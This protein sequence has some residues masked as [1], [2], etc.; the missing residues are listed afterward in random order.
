MTFGNLQHIYL[1]IYA[2]VFGF[3][4]VLGVRAKLKLDINDGSAAVHLESNA[5]HRSSFQLIHLGGLFMEA[6]WS[7]Q[8]P[9]VTMP[10]D[11]PAFKTGPL[12][13]FVVFAFVREPRYPFPTVEF[14]FYGPPRRVENRTG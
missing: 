10:T 14:Q 6:D 13:H 2:T 9:G 4:Y 5:P 7:L 1:C 11:P 3:A 12:P 8:S